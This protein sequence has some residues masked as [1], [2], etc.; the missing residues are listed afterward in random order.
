MTALT[1][2]VLEQLDD[3][4]AIKVVTLDIR[5]I[6]T[7]ADYMIIATGNSSRHVRAIA[8]NLVQKAKEHHYPPI[9]VEGANE[10]EWVLVDLGDVIVHIMQAETREFYN[11]EKLW[12]K[13]EAPLSA[14]A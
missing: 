13:I 9:G 3:M 2:L 8:D 1:E 12:G 6:T 7:L 10:A 11:L 4:K 5:A 14:F